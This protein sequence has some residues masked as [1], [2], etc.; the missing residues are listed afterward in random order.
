MTRF[1]PPTRP[2]I[3]LVEDEPL[4]RETNVDVLQEAGFRVIEAS[5]ADEAFGLLRHRPDVGVV[6]TDVDMPGSIDGFE[7]ARLTAQGWPD[8]RVVVISGKTTPGS[9]DLPPEA[10][11]LAKPFRP[12]TLTGLLRRLADRTELHDARSGEDDAGMNSP[13]DRTSGAGTRA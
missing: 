4:V 11:F 5:N 9:G 13:G 7:F 12:E 1:S 3:L 2:L 8:V 6:L 10:V